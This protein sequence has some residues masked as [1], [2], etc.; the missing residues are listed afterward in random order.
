MKSAPAKV[1]SKGQITIPQDVRERLRLRAGDRVVFRVPEGKGRAASMRPERGGSA[2]D[3]A[4]IPDLVALGG[5]LRPPRGRRGRPWSEVR[6]TAWD[7][8]VRRR[9]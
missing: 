4:K 7:E 6:G 9:A 1:T 5:S 8:E 3:M 2:V